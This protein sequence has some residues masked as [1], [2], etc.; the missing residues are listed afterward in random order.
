MIKR[1]SL[2][3]MMSLTNKAMLCI[4]LLLVI[5]SDKVEEL[6]INTK[7]GM[8]VALSSILYLLIHTYVSIR[9]EKDKNYEC[10]SLLVD[11]TLTTLF[12]YSYQR[13]DF[14]SCGFIALITFKYY[15][16]LNV[17]SWILYLSVLYCLISFLVKEWSP[18]LI[19]ILLMS[20]SF[21]FFDNI[22]FGAQRTRKVLNDLIDNIFVSSRGQIYQMYKKALDVINLIPGM[23]G[24]SSIY[25]FQIVGDY[26]YVVN[27]S[28]YLWNY[29]I[30]IERV[31]NYL[32]TQR[33]KFFKNIKFRSNG[34]E[35][36]DNICFVKPS[37]DSK[38]FFL[39]ILVVESSKTFVWY[40]QLYL[41]RF[42]SRMTYVNESELDF[43]RHQ[44]EQAKEMSQKVSYVNL[45]TTTLHFI[46]NKITPFKDYMAIHRDI[47]N[48]EGE[49]KEKAKEY[50]D[51]EYSHMEDSFNAI[52]TRAHKLID[53]EDNPFV[54]SDVKPYAIEQLFSEIKEQWK[55]YELD[56]SK[57]Q[58]HIQP[59]RPG[60]AIRVKYN[61][62]GIGIVVDNWISNIDK[63]CNGDYK[64]DFTET[65]EKISISCGNTID[66]NSKINKKVVDMFNKNLRA[67]INRRDFHGLQIIKELTSRMEISS[68]LT[69]GK[70]NWIFLNI[71]IDKV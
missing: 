6:K 2:N 33:Y 34:T 59:K 65:D 43:K 68:S 39:F 21:Y 70:D 57:I 67:E 38:S 10:V 13:L 26:A 29:T 14:L 52:I 36:N 66:K 35:F 3:R 49:K 46:R 7:M 63:Y 42:L 30:D 37:R 17:L 5:A 44:R 9:I 54:F 15:N 22:V 53:E 51:K 69:L 41:L 4:F 47:D 1:I 45:A 19:Y 12:F 24:V 23:Q 60:I 27:G 48:L 31:Y 71:E 58:T 40:F 56:E 64:L 20:L 8:I 62:E 25:C 32:P 55:S 50:L 16:H 18:L 11:L 61:K 28:D